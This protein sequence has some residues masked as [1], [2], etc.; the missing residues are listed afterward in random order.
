MGT[1][2]LLASLVAL[3]TAIGSIRPASATEQPNIL[4]VMTDDQPKDTM[5]AMPEVRGRVRDRGMALPNAYVSESICCPSRASVLSGQYSHNTGVMRNDPPDGGVQT[6]RESGYEEDSLPIWLRQQGYATALVGKYMNGYDA[7][8]EPPGWNYWFAKADGNT[9]GS[10]ANENGRIIDFSGMT[11]NMGDRYRDKALGFLDKRTD[12]ATDRPFAMF[13]WTNQP[14]L[15]ANGYADRYAD[16]YSDATLRPKPS[17]NEPGVSDKPRWVQNIGRID[18]QE[19]TQL[20]QWRRNQ[21]RSVRQVDDTVGAMLD[22]LRKRGELGNTYVVFTSDN[23]THMGEHRWFDHHGAK[24]TAYEEAANVPMYVRGPGIHPG[25]TSRKLVLNTDLA[26][27][28]VNIATGG[29]PP[30]FVN[31]LDGRNLLPLWS[32]TASN[33]RTA[34]MTEHPLEDDYPVPP[35]H[36]IIT[37]RHT[38]VEYDTTEDTSEKELYDRVSDPHELESKHADTTYDNTRSALSARLHDLEGCMADV[39]QM[40]ENGP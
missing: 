6:F 39:C 7:S 27:T 33:W 37:Q 15:E 24:A 23:S 30:E 17:F 10:T 26:P 2:V 20:I 16:L 35:Y 14:H 1:A 19:K 32:G 40:A 31:G 8:Y 21:L 11:G 9:P 3:V 36:A 13:F 25:S 29:S 18:T 34:I 12:Q 28:F 5:L 4:F 38:Y 22:L